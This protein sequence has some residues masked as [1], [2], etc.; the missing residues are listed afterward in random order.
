MMTWTQTYDPLGNIGLSALIAAIPIIFFFLA[1]TVFRLKGHIAGLG[2][3]IST[4][5][6]ALFFYKMPIGMA[7]MATFNGM[8]YGLWPISWIIITAV[9]LYKLSV[10]S[11]QFE[12]IRDSVISVTD[13]QRLQVILIGFSFGAFLEGSAGFGAPVAITAGILVALGLQPLYAAGL[14]LIANTAPVAFG[15]LGIPIL[16]AGKTTGIDPMLIGMM[17]GRQ[18]P[19]LSMFVPFFLVWLMDGY[20]GVRQTWPAVLVAGLSFALAQYYTSNYIGPELPDIT[21]ALVSMLALS[22]FLKFWQPKEAFTF[23]IDRCQPRKKSPPTHYSLSQ[24][25][26]AWSPFIVLTIIVIIWSLPQFKALFAKGGAL[27][28]LVF[29]FHVPG[30]DNLVIKTTPIV[31]SDTPYAAEYKFD[32]ISATGSGI[33]LAALITMALLRIRISDG[34]SVFAETLQELLRPIFSIACVLGF[35]YLA[36]YSGLSSTL[37]LAL[38]ST[39][40]FFPFFSPVLGWLGVFLTGSDTSSNA[41]FSSLQSITAQQIGVSEVLLVAANTTGG[42]TGKMI[43]PQSIAVACAAVGLVGRESDL[44]RFTIKWSFM[45]LLL[46]CIMTYIQA[47]YLT[48]MIPG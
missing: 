39:G 19:L 41:L 2:T 27:Y 30:L 12:I 3:I 42:V 24:I 45:F 25:L 6:V 22:V 23:G 18:L 29:S 1:L 4:L 16:V 26:K 31:T 17:A 7:L 36:N 14:C 28:S 20:R 48:G 38:A 47:Y 9:F 10:K 46:L 40:K 8:W 5:A 11:G 33:L 21:S 13:D 32:L 37:A 35:A 34:I 44:F 15:A 43:S